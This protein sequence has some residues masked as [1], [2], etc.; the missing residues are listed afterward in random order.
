MGLKDLPSAYLKER[1]LD[2]YIRSPVYYQSS[3]SSTT[4]R[5]SEAPLKSSNF[6]QSKVDPKLA[7]YGSQCYFSALQSTTSTTQLSRTN[8]NLGSHDGLIGSEYL[9]KSAI[10]DIQIDGSS[11]NLSTEDSWLI[12]KQNTVS[13][14]PPWYSEVAELSL[15]LVPSTMKII[16]PDGKL[17]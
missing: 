4:Q 11:S 10:N 15:V 3:L 9:M 1:C 17:N 5:N 16:A 13:S 7:E 14:V 8:S 12:I 2:H 6:F